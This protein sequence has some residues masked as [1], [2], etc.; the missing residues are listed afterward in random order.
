MRSATGYGPIQGRCRMFEFGKKYRLTFQHNDG[1]DSRREVEGDLEVVSVEIP[2][3]KFQ[4]GD[5]QF[6]VNV[7]SPA[8]VKGE[9]Q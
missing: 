7:A 8:F 1:K 5:R 9:L 3:V 4:R 6:V 2:L